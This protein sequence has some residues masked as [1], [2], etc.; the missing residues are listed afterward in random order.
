M[1][2]SPLRVGSRSKWIKERG[3]EMGFGVFGG[4][5]VRCWCRDLV[6]VYS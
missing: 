2:G 5:E 3:L 4:L 6:N 1:K